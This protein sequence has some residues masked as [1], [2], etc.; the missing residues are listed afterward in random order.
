M[1]FSFID[2]EDS[3]DDLP[4]TKKASREKYKKVG[5]ELESGISLQGLILQ[6]VK[7]I[8]K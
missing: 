2:P 8:A 5:E 7:K 1:L 4:F 3:D 6:L